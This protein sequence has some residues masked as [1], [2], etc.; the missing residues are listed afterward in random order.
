MLRIW[1]KKS[2]YN[3]NMRVFGTRQYLSWKSSVLTLTLWEIKLYSLWR[4]G[5]WTLGFQFQDLTWVFSAHLICMGYLG[6]WFTSL[7]SRYCL[8]NPTV[9]FRSGWFQVFLSRYGIVWSDQ[10]NWKK[11][12]D[13]QSKMGTETN[14]AL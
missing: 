13:F 12:G 14:A 5:S 2:W 8:Q 9:L 11:V 10:L 3:W 7:V 6:I 1:V 4:F